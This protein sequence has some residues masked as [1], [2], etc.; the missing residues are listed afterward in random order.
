MLH[1]RPSGRC[2]IPSMARRMSRLRLVILVAAMP[3]ALWMLVPVLSDGAPLS[4]RIESKKR[5]IEEKK[6]GHMVALQSPHIVTVPVD[7]VLA[8]PKRVDPNHDI[9]CLA[10]E[11]GISLGE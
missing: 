1:K 3:L 4:S 9:V 6:W 8:A 10:R 5:A 2:P 7:E 11:T